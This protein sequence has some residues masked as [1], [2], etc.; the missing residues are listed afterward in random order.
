MIYRKFVQVGY[1]PERLY[2][3][4]FVFHLN[5]THISVQT[6]FCVYKVFINSA[7]SYIS[8]PNSL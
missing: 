3:S 8:L 2:M 1:L 6:A 7:L 4:T 5:C